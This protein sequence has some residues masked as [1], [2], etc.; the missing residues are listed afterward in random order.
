MDFRIL[1]QLEVLD[2]GRDVAPRRAKHRALLTALLLH[3]NQLM[4]TDRLIDSLWGDV[5]P[6]TAAK[7]LQGHV[8]ALRKLIGRERIRTEHGGYRLEVLPGE[9]D[10]DRFESA[11]QVARSTAEPDERAKLLAEALATWR[12]D[13]LA[14]LRYEA[15]AQS[16]IERL[17][18]LR[19]GAL[20]ERIEADLAAGR[21]AEVLPELERYIAGHPLRERLRE[22]H[23]LALYR[24]GRQAEALR[25][26]QDVRRRL[27]EELGIDTGPALQR[28][29]QR[30][31]AQDPGLEPPRVDHPRAI[32]QER[33]WVTVVVFGV[34][35]YP[36]DDPE[37]LDAAVAPARARIDT[38]VRRF[39]GAVQ[40]LFA[41]ALLGV[42][43]AHQAHED[44][45]ER[46]VR[47]AL[48]SAEA[49]AELGLKLHAAVEAG[50]AL[51]TI[52]GDLVEL[53]GEVLSAAN[54]LHIAAPPGEILVSAAV[55]RATAESI[56]YVQLGDEAWRATGQLRSPAA[57]AIDRTTATFVGR[58]E[59]LALLEGG[60]ARARRER[61]VQVVTIV[62]EPGTGKTRLVQEL[63]AA[64][65]TRG[66]THTWR[67]GRC[68]PYGEGVTYWALGEIVKAEADILETTDAEEARGRLIATAERLAEDADTRAWLVASLA[69]LVGIAGPH[70][71]DQGQSIAAFRE[72]LQRIARHD[73]LVLVLEDLQWADAALIDF[74]DDLVARVI[75]PVLVVC[76][77]RSEFVDVRPG[78]AAGAR[79]AVWISLSPL[80]DEEISTLL[81]ELL[82]QPPNT[83]MVRRAGGNPLFAHELARRLASGDARPADLP[84]SIQAVI[85]SRLDAM[86]W[87]LRESASSAAVV[88]EVF[89][90]DSIV[91]IEGLSPGEANRRLQGLVARDV[92]R[93]AGHSTVR[94]TEEYTFVHSLVRDAAYDRLPRAERSRRH[95]AAAAW[96][97]RLA[98]D[99]TIDH[100][101]FL[102]HHLTAALAAMDASASPDVAAA[103]KQ[104]T[105]R[106]LC[107]AGDRAIRL[108]V[109]AAERFYE[110]ALG[111][112]EVG[113]P[114]RPGALVRL[115]DAAQEANRL[116]EAVGW[117]EEALAAL[118]ATGDQVAIA[119]AMDGLARAYWR[120]GETKRHA[121]VVDEAIA[122][123][124]TGP[125]GPELVRLWGQKAR[126][127][128]LDGRPAEA[129]PW[130]DRA[131]AAADA[132]GVPEVRML[133]LM[134]GDIARNELGQAVTLEGL[135]EAVR[136][137]H[138][139]GLGFE[140]AVAYSNLAV[141]VAHEEG[142]A[143]A[144]AIVQTAIEFSEQRGL[145]HMVARARSAALEFRLVMGDW[146]G[147][148]QEA[149]AELEEERSQGPTQQ[150]TDA[151][152]TKADVL[153]GRGRLHEAAPI[154]RDLLPAAR[155][156][157]G[158]QVLAPVLAIAA[159]FDVQRGEL[160]SAR[161]LIKELE[162]A[163]RDN[164][165]WRSYVVADA[166]RAS[167]AASDLALA[168]QMEAG[169]KAVPHRN[170]GNCWRHARPSPRPMGSW[171][172]RCSCTRGRR[173]SGRR[174]GTC[175]STVRRCSAEAAAW[176]C[177]AG[178]RMLA[179]P[180]M[181]R[182]RSSISSRHARCSRKQRV[183]F[184]GP[185]PAPEGATVDRRST[186]PTNAAQP[187]RGRC[188]RYSRKSSFVTTP[189][190]R[191]P[192]TATSAAAPSESSANASSRLAEASTSG[193]GGSMTSP[194]V[195][196]TTSGLR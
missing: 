132:A 185:R 53:T 88:G 37:S 108:D 71:S 195:R 81:G 135:R 145:H 78:W 130:I 58:D 143:A 87:D 139:L 77:A 126:G 144:M 30:I 191:S 76:T 187:D 29:G 55:R 91:A 157:G 186:G 114:D 67:E 22:L 110:R 72:L 101:E 16:E 148:L 80:A 40:P 48:A 158:L 147:A 190:G 100:A 46:G 70:A 86:P 18:T 31:L 183:G 35:G 6:D 38:A 117:Y 163:T 61:R 17:E 85:A 165:G 160:A 52:D 68:V 93:P 27:S 36:R 12:G 134:Y 141:E 56:A 65:A 2:E 1:G 174:L 41:N 7:A 175:S 172:G 142:P 90:A 131:A 161:A 125:V 121:E 64:L 42:F 162:K 167:L 146:D 84:E 98:G 47:A 156:I 189:A 73:P 63:R 171:T 82:G 153:V 14:D 133:M 60:F 179:S 180:W 44:D 23:M 140:T 164:S 127:L 59:D 184:S 155:H 154:V 123:L 138:E 94:A 119:G 170:H 95:L 103:L 97:E 105:A 107:L 8:L 193:S 118:E 196:S 66:E 20:E 96:I 62:G 115:A 182:G 149:E 92:V 137:G 10:L 192:R 188:D 112:L 57:R 178:L 150:A 129:L 39:G 122:R 152:V 3:P 168:V 28:L 5:P 166:V 13:P 109:A 113:H 159:R 9:I 19:I 173:R 15:F 24:S 124:A 116:R 111:L 45:A 79:N 169:T 51:V 50:D 43:G 120:L 26:Y 11:L 74:V 54:R 75:G 69:P 128:V 181:P 25:V 102:A 33:K 83:E 177:S 104:K 49:I 89:W 34:T 21:H 99:R 106:F 176:C 194:T 136:L 4:A 32:R 151:L